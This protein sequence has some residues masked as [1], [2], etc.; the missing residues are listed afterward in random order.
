MITL[1]SIVKLFS[2]VLF[3]LINT[4]VF[5][6]IIKSYIKDFNKNNKFVFIGIGFYMSPTLVY[7]SFLLGS[8]TFWILLH[9]IA[10]A[11]YLYLKRLHSFK[12]AIN[13]IHNKFIYFGL[14]IILI[15]AIYVYFY[16]AVNHI[17]INNLDNLNTYDWAYY[18]YYLKIIYPPALMGFLVLLIED[19]NIIFYLNYIGA[20]LG[21]L[22]LLVII[23]VVKSFLSIN[24][25]FLLTAIL[26]S[27]F[28]NILTIMRFG[29]H[30]GSV[31][32]VVLVT[33]LSLLVVFLRENI[34]RKKLSLILIFNALI[35]VQA[36][37]TSIPQTATFI[38]LS[39]FLITYLI[40][41]RFISLNYGLLFISS[42]ILGSL[43][44]VTYQK[45]IHIETTL[46]FITPSSSSSSSVFLDAVKDFVLPVGLPRP[47]F[48]SIYSF[49]AWVLLP[50][51]FYLLYGAHKRRNIPLLIFVLSTLY[52]WIV[53][54]FGVFEFSYSKGRAAWN[55]LL[56][57]P[58]CIIIFL[59]RF[60]NRLKPTLLFSLLLISAVSSLVLPPVTYRIEPEEAL[61]RFRNLVTN[62][63]VQLY[64]DF[65]S[66]RV[67]GQNI[68][69]IN[70]E[71]LSNNYGSKYVLLN[72][73]NRLPDPVLSNL[74]RF[75]DRDL[76]N[77]Y[78]D[79]ENIINERLLNHAL[80]IKNLK[81]NGY[82]VI[83]E[84]LEFIIL[85]SK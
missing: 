76:N 66:A 83:S 57:A 21:L 73:S 3:L 6:E 43:L 68:E 24:Q 65:S 50:I 49:G 48:D 61:F 7:I 13:F 27:P 59:S 78:K 81:Q 71:E 45:K 36:G 80:L 44:S 33:F 85:K 67:L 23:W 25:S 41:F 60:I 52:Y 69:L 26:L 17:S 46:T 53:T 30:A 2:L 42:S 47:I 51:L 9:L 62:K 28:L 22:S 39:F 8:K 31:F 11:L 75:E 32:Q 10:Y 37:I 4:H 77:F 16:D 5:Y 54:Q 12:L 79:Q 72:L 74:K 40:I 63:D 70:E 35:F 18:N 55:L 34:S 29:L 20:T 64:S 14:L 38:I 1:D 82:T 19:V 84:T 15:T 58:I 56:L